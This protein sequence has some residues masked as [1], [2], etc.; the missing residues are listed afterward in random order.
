ML[1]QRRWEMPSEAEISRWSTPQL[2]QAVTRRRPF[3]SGTCCGRPA[4]RLSA[5]WRFPGFRRF[6]LLGTEGLY[7]LIACAAGRIAGRCDAL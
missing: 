1:A 7:R 2:L 5:F 3:S 4:V 6:G